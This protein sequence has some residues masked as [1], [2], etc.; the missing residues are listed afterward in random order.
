MNYLTLDYIKAHSRIDA[1]TE[2]SLLEL[3]GN[4]AEEMVLNTINMTYDEVIAEYV[5]FP[6]AL[7]HATLM[8]VD[9]SYQMRSPVGVQN[10]SDIPY[11]FDFLVK[12]YMKL[13]DRGDSDESSSES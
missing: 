4:S 1:D 9:L 5:T 6:K 13:S 12:P 7:I 10:L 11:T 2:D 3:Y 8:L